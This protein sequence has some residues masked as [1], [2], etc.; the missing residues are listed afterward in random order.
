MKRS[1]IVFFILL[2]LAISYFII[3]TNGIAYEEPGGMTSI[4][5]FS[6]D[7]SRLTK[8]YFIEGDKLISETR[9]ITVKMLESEFAAIQALK[10]GP[11]LDNQD[12][13]IARDVKILSVITT[14]RVCYVNLSNEF[15]SGNEDRLY[16]NVTSIVNTLTEFESI[17][18][19]QVLVEGKKINAGDGIMSVPMTKN[20]SRVQNIEL[21]PKEIAR[22]FLTYI[23]QKRYDLA[24]DLIDSESKTGAT[25]REFKESAIQLNEEIKG[26]TLSYIFA[27]REQGRYII[28]VKYVLRDSPSN[29]DLLKN[30]N[31]REELPFS[32][33]MILE[34]NLWKIKFFG[35]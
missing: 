22:K 11:K 8:L 28:Q 19:V 33:P 29:N 2:L 6:N 16:L 5:P 3:S 32:W 14:D 13:P 27:K 21:D 25:Y 7:F 10:A 18:Y 1:L 15:L 34:N 4:S 31:I 26:Y 24:Y 9:S 23:S 30:G 35:Y 17:D 12:S 20:T